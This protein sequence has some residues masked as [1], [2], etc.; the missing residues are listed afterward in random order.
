MT[1]PASIDDA[2]LSRLTGMV[3]S[4][5]GATY[6]LTEVYTGEV[7]TALPQSTPA[8][9][10]TAYAA[11]AR[12]AGRLGAW[13]LKKR[14]AV[15]KRFHALLLKKHEIVVDLMQVETGK[16]RRMSFEEICD[17]A[18]DDEPLPQERQADP[19]RAQARRRRAG[20]LDLG[21]EVRVP[22]GV[23]GL[24]SPVELPLRH[25]PVRRDARADR[26]QRRRAQAGQQ[27]ARCASPYGVELLYE[28]GHARRGWCRSS[29]ARGPTSGRRSIDHADFVMFT[30]S[31]ATGRFIGEQAG[32]NLIDCTLE[33][34]GK[35]PLIVLRRRRP[36]RDRRRR[37]LRLVPQRRPGLH[38]HRADLRRRASSRRSSPAGS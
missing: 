34:G 4:T 22:K 11:R 29:A 31:T 37:A 8:D 15:M 18:D 7:I 30:G 2:L 19:G 10:A 28:A 13:P 20:R 26:R 21:T 25:Q 35:N 6:K 23:I 27:D 16:A 38:A 36:R 3:A 17:V 14:L 12:G 32:R 9:V 33:L 24:I 5:G 1:L